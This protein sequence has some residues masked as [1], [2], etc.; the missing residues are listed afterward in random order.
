MRRIAFGIFLLL[1]TLCTGLALRA[2]QPSSSK[3]EVFAGKDPL[4]GNWFRV[5]FA[6][7]GAVRSAA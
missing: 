6:H 3:Q 1:L 4:R 7:V 5:A 2:Q